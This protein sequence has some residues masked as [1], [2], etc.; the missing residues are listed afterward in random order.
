VGP[1]LGRRPRH[2]YNSQTHTH[3][4]FPSHEHRRG[5]IACLTAFVLSAIAGVVFLATGS[6]VLAGSVLLILGLSCAAETV[7]T[8]RVRATIN[9]QWLV[10]QNDWQV[11][12]A[13]TSTVAAVDIARRTGHPLDQWCAQVR[14]VNGREF[15]IDAL[16]NLGRADAELSEEWRDL[17][18]ILRHEL[19]VGGET[20]TQRR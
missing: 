10:A 2:I 1:P 8:I 13:D 3:C 7:L 17:V 12:R 16:R 19:G 4:F 5:Q 6:G 15:W 18:A 20:I 9:P 14:L 11:R